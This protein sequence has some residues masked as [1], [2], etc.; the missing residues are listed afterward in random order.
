[1][2]AILAGKVCFQIQIGNIR[3]S[4]RYLRSC[5]DYSRIYQQ[6]MGVM[7]T[8]DMIGCKM[9]GLEATATAWKSLL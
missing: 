2:T 3:Q 6:G 5:E 4:F 8:R 1:M 9:V 7:L